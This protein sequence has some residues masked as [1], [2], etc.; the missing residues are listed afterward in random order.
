MLDLKSEDLPFILNRYNVHMEKTL[1]PDEAAEQLY[2][3]DE[4]L[5]AVAVAIYE[6]EEDDVRDALDALLDA[7]HDPL[8]N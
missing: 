3:R 4:L 2:P 6:G 1:T 5:K 7:G 8:I